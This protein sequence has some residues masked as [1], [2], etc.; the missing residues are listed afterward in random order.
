MMTFGSKLR[1]L[2]EAR[3]MTQTDLARILG[4]SPKAVSKWEANRMEPRPPMVAKIAQALGVTKDE[5][6]HGS[7]PKPETTSAPETD[8]RLDRAT[9]PLPSPAVASQIDQILRRATA[10]VL[11]LVAGAIRQG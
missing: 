6:V 1:Q 8:K 11:E 4:V 9:A 10:E 3:G 5:L 2:R 7:S